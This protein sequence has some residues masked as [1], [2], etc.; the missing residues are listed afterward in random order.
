M[1]IIDSKYFKSN[2]NE[3]I[4]KQNDENSFKFELEKMLYMIIHENILFAY[5]WSFSLN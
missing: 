3:M 1:L 5:S 2:T 4:H